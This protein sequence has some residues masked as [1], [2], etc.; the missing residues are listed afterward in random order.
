MKKFN[1]RKT[2]IPKGQIEDINIDK[3]LANNTEKVFQKK[4]R[5]KLFL[6]DER[7]PIYL[8]DVYIEPR[9]VEKRLNGRKKEKEKNNEVINC[10]YA[11]EYIN[12]F[13]LNS[14]DKVLFIEGVAG[15][16]K[17]SLLSKLST[18]MYSNDIF[19]KSL[20]DYL[21]ID[22]VQLKREIMKTFSLSESDYNKVLFLD[23][24]DEIWS[25]IDPSEFG[26]DLNYFIERD[27]K[28]VFTV[29]P[30]YVLYSSYVNVIKLC[31]LEVFGTKE[32]NDWIKKYKYLKKKNLDDNVI[33]HIVEDTKFVEITSI[34][35][36]LYIISNRNIDLNDIVSIPQLY[37]RVFDSLK[38]DKGNKTK[39]KLENDYIC[40]QRIAYLMQA[41][42]VLTLTKKELVSLMAVD[43]S[44]Y[45]SVYMDK[46]IEGEEVLEF[47]HKSIQEFFA[48]KWI[49]SQ[50][51]YN[52]NDKYALILSDHIF[53]K[54]LLVNLK[55]FLNDA[56]CNINVLFSKFVCDGFPY[57]KDNICN[58]N[59]YKQYLKNI[60]I[61]TIN[62]C[63]EILH[64]DIEIISCLEM[65]PF[66]DIVEGINKIEKKIYEIRSIKFE[67][68]FFRHIFI[69][70][71]NFYNIVFDESL[72]K[73]CIFEYVT[74]IH[75]SFILNNEESEILFRNC[76]F[77]NVVFYTKKNNINFEN[78]TFVLY[79]SKFTEKIAKEIRKCKLDKKSL[80]DLQNCVD[81]YGTK[82]SKAD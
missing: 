40:A 41:K 47:V 33:K 56:P 5:K 81:Y 17:S 25:K 10:D 73:N 13:V 20:K 36:M 6:E 64:S 82:N 26:D 70:N 12:K 42:G 1:E 3:K 35:I 67:R 72:F 31:E 7:V 2:V 79:N 52:V 30:G 55:F 62:I 71:Y 11:V 66:F 51:R 9:L 54:E 57:Y 21:D 4:Y 53:S 78:C 44:F 29:R 39:R 50:I 38:E 65:Q 23:G 28:V 43:D 48:A 8:C 46:I 15:A 77:N 27:Y 58:W 80:S 69:R 49:Y 24:L 59:Q 32:K 76:Q 60:V 75:C 19:Y 16:G 18:V 45:S 37:E 74:F 61:N 34:P 63:S 14:N 22:S 68:C